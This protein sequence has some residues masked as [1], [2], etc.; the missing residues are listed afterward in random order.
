MYYIPYLYAKLLKGI[1]F[2]YTM[3]TITKTKQYSNRST[4]SIR[5]ICIHL[6]CSNPVV[7]ISLNLHTHTRNIF[8]NDEN[9]KKI[10][11][12]HLPHNK[13]YRS[14][15]CFLYRFS[16]FFL[17]CNICKLI[18]VHYLHYIVGRTSSYLYYN[19]SL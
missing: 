4:K 17:C 9:K 2:Y 8:R 11:N 10:I 12:F 6:L 5:S 1:N 14:L 13:I 15:L 16:T 7:V 18:Y 3:S 19:I